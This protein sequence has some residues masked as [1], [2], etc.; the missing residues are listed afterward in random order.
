MRYYEGI[1]VGYRYYDTFGVPVAFPFGHGLS[2]A[3]FEYSNLKINKLS[4][5][6]YEVSYDITNLSDI[7]AKEI[8]QV[9]VKDVISIASRPE[10]E[11]KGFSKD[12]IKAGETKTITIKLDF[13]SFAFWNL[14]LDKWFVENGT[15]EILVG[16]SLNDIRLKGKIQIEQDEDSMPSHT[17]CV[18]I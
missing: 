12:L 5:T 14:A 17:C 10:K 3:T 15:F 18:E 4:D 9:Y 7:D 2:Y 1:Y 8:S 6:D 16:A 13:R 11:L